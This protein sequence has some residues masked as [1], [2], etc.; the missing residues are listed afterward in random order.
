MKRFAL[1][2]GFAAYF[3]A[4]GADM[5]VALEKAGLPCDLFKKPRPKVS[6]YAWASFMTHALKLQGGG[7]GMIGLVCNPSD[8]AFPPQVAAAWCS[9]NGAARRA[10][11]W[12]R[13]SSSS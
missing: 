8:S 12:G 2:S 4:S 9:R 1:D 5:S 11:N 10:L 13:P 6:A 3:G 7:R